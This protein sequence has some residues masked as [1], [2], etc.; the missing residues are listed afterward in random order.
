MP[1]LPLPSPRR[2]RGRGRHRPA[3]LPHFPQFPKLAALTLRRARFGGASRRA[4]RERDRNNE[5]L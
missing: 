5:P 3:H 4:E 1:C 2:Y